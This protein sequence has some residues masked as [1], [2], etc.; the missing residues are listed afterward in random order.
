MTVAKFKD[1]F[2]PWLDRL[3]LHRLYTW[4]RENKTVIKVAICKI[5]YA[6]HIKRIRAKPTGEKIRVLFIVSEI[7]K[8]KEQK[9]YE[10]MAGS[11]VFEPLIGLSA[12]NRQA[13]LLAEE[14]S[15]VHNHAE[16]FFRRLGDKVVH[17]VKVVGDK[18]IYCDLSEFSPDIVYYTE[19]WS[20]C[21]KQDPWVVSKFALTV[22]TPYFTPNYGVLSLDCHQLVHRLL[23]AYFTLNEAWGSAYRRSLRFVAHSTRFVPT[24]HPSLDFYADAPNIPPRKNSVIYAPHFSFFNPNEPNYDQRYSTF[25]KNRNEILE[26]AKRHPEF[27][28][29]F[30]PHPILREWIMRSGLMTQE[31]VDNYFAEWAKIGV[32]CEDGD[33]QDL[34]LDSFAIITDCGSFLTEYG[35]TGRPVIHLICSANKYTPTHLIKRLYDTYYQVH[36]IDEMQAIFGLVLENRKDPMKE[37]RLAEARN[38]GILNS[39]AAH[40]IKHYFLALFDKNV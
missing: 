39:N 15:V 35:A 21:E 24:G 31:E 40:C 12:W 28:W 34:F 18:K 30:K 19:P 25:D 17:T 1:T 6:K 32:V 14:L 26:Y 5:R 3:H 10:E 7:A 22:Y 29:V 23:Y 13:C 8:W 36:S 37:K 9:V 20:P 2:R 33:Y 38:A 16:L 4:L 27:N 11:D